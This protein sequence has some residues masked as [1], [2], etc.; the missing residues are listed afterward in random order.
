MGADR[1]GRVRDL[2]YTD[3]T[4]PGLGRAGRGEGGRR[5]VRTGQAGWV[6][7]GTRTGP[8]LG[9]AGHRRVRAGVR[10]GGSPPVTAGHRRLTGNG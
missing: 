4:G 3:R 5:G 1:A 9:R 2:R 10:Q 7:C 6:I 8:G